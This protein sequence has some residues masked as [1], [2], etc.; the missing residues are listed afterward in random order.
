[1]ANFYVNETTQGLGTIATAQASTTDIYRV[2][3]KITLPTII[4]G[5]PAPSQVVVTIN[6]NGSP[7]YTGLA[8][9]EGFRA[10]PA[11]SAGD[12]ITVVLTSS[13]P[14]DA[15]LNVIKSTISISEGV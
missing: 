3:G 9:A 15:A 8:G 4:Q 11:C 10:N 13:A 12:I 7:V 5:S 14:T 1:M 2:S 6:V